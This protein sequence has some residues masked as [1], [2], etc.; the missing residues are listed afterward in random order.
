MSASAGK[1]LRVPRRKIDMGRGEEGRP[2]IDGLGKS[3]RVDADPV[4]TRHHD[5]F[6]LGAGRKLIAECGKVE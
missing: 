5:E 3:G 2:L 4:V 1:V 6:H